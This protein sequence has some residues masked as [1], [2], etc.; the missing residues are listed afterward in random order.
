MENET[1]IFCAASSP[2]TIRGKSINLL[3]VDEFAFIDDNIADKFMQTVFP[4]LEA[5][6]DSM[7]ILISTPKGRNHFYNIW[8]K[9]INNINS[10]IPCKVQWYEVEGRDEKWLQKKIQDHGELFVRQEYMCL[11]GEEPVTVQYEQGF[12]KMLE[13]LTMEELYVRQEEGLLS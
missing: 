7:M 12:Y 4:T 3:L 9:A 10:F 13:E 8:Q 11:A 2:N 1:K 5:K 6:S